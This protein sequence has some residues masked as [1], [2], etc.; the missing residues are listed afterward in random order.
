MRIIDDLRAYSD[1]STLRMIS[2]ILFATNFRAVMNYRIAH[3]FGKIKLVPVCKLIM[4]WNRVVHSVDVDYRADLAGG[5]V[6]VHGIGVVIGKDVK[7][8]GR[9]RIY[10][11]VTLGGNN[12]KERTHDRYGKL[13]QPVLE[14]NVTVFSGACLFGP[15]VI[16]ENS[17]VGAMTVCT[18]D[19]PANVLYYN[20][21]EHIIKDLAAL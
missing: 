8:L 13:S 6:L 15:I 5:F 4:A 14:N 12:G 18:H 11:H 16:G 9:A 20:K 3:F 21:T 17:R 1:G 7:T 2:T 19:I 10:Q